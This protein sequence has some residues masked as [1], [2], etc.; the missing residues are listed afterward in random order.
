MAK[1]TKP[2]DELTTKPKPVEPPKTPDIK[3]GEEEQE[4]TNVEEEEKD[5]N[6]ENPKNKCFEMFKSLG[7]NK[8]AKDEQAEYS[9]GKALVGKRLDDVKNWCEYLQEYLGLR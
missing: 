8:H 9:R 3:P 4:S 2:K 1:Q 6:F 7:I 5:V